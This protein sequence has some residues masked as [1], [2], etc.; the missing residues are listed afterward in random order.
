[1]SNGWVQPGW[2]QPGWV[3]GAVGG[4]VKTLKARVTP[5]VQAGFTSAPDRQR[6]PGEPVREAVALQRTSLSPR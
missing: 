5:Q 3:Q 4:G 6:N 1:M 2:V